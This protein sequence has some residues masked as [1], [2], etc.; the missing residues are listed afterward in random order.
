MS[1]H[2]A[3]EPKMCAIGRMLE[4]NL[5]NAAKAANAARLVVESVQRALLAG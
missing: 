3:F 2:G 1:N 5:L 4:A